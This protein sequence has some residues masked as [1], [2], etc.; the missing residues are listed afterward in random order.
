MEICV[1]R[2]PFFFPAS[3]RGETDPEF[4]RVFLVLLR[5][6]YYPAGNFL[7][8]FLSW[9][10]FFAGPETKFLA[11]SHK[12]PETPQMEAGDWIVGVALTFHLRPDSFWSMEAI[13]FMFFLLLAGNVLSGQE[14]ETRGMAG[15]SLLVCSAAVGLPPAPSV[16]GLSPAASAG[17]TPWSYPG[18]LVVEAPEGFFSSYPEGLAASFFR[19][20]P[21]LPE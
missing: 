5:V 2:K 9:R 7:P 21:T 10:S 13:E 4:P 6:K 11:A 8:S 14:A 3:Y 15:S 12:L 17:V 18:D 19:C 1:L 16:A 20:G